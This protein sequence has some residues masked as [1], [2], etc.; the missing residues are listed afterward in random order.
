MCCT[1]SESILQF[2]I[3]IKMYTRGR[4][5]VVPPHQSA[6]MNLCVYQF[7]N[8]QLSTFVFENAARTVVTG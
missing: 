7:I 8:Y 2:A 1:A 3:W 4:K 6:C 5:A